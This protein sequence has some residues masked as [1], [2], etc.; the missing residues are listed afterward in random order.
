MDFVQ[1]NSVLPLFYLQSKA[2][3]LPFRKRKPV[4]TAAWVKAGG[5]GGREA[6][7]GG[8][9]AEGPTAA[10]DQASSRAFLRMRREGH[11]VYFKSR[12]LH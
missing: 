9:E 11:Y 5:G 4:Y 3:Q 12:E 7:W 8:G 2:T 10:E 6:V 1:Q